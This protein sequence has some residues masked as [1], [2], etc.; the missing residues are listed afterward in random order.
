MA[1]DNI[2]GRPYSLRVPVQCVCLGIKIRLGNIGVRSTRRFRNCRRDDVT[3]LRI[4]AAIFSV[5]VFALLACGSSTDS[6]PRVT[7]AGKISETVEDPQTRLR[8]GADSR[9]AR[10]SAGSITAAE[11]ASAEEIAAAAAA[12]EAIFPDPLIEKK[13]RANI[14]Q[15]K[16]PILISDLE[17]VIK[18]SSASDLYVVDLTG[19]EHLVNLT[20]YDVSQN[21]VADISPL[22]SL[23]NLTRLN[24][25]QN[26]ISD[27]SAL[28]SLTNLTFLW[29]QDN[30]VSDISALASLTNLT[31]LHLE[32]NEISDISALASLTN[33]TVLNLKN[34][35]ITDLS[36]LASLSNL[37]S[38]ELNKND[39][40]DI[41]P[42]LEIGLG[43]GTKITLYGLKLD[44]NSK[45]V[46]IPEL[47]AAGIKVL[48]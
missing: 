22:A 41:S 16:G 3:R 42:L 35:N 47:R 8:G 44:A 33:L 19:L 12:G 10:R 2:S 4:L 5:M 45:E 38:L 13:L 14:D 31:E 28:A 46:V 48:F 25:S 15:P 20:E 30:L 37:T 6:A 29:N 39:I 23:I 43:E 40:T 21:R 27:I 9:R 32:A 36:P 17:Q 7:S 34:N 18:F 1:V 24:I 26:D 11:G